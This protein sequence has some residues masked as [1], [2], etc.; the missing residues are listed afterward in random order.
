MWFGGGGSMKII[1]VCSLWGRLFIFIFIFPFCTQKNLL[2]TK[3]KS[4]LFYQDVLKFLIKRV[5]RMFFHP[6]LNRMGKIDNISQ[7]NECCKL[8]LGGYF[9]T[10]PGKH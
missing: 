5:R 4:L 3:L 2:K 1:V 8:K 9:V 10:P 7:E 6:K